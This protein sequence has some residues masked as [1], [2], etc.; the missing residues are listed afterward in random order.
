MYQRLDE[1]VVELRTRLG[2]LPSP[3]EAEGI[4][5]DIWHQEAHNST[6]L[7][8]NT[9]VLQEVERLLEEG[10]AVGA[11]PLRDYMEVRG[12]GDAA[13]W[14]YGQALHPGQ[15]ADSELVSMQEVR[16]I[17]HLAM[18]PVWTVAPHE[19]AGD[20]EG[21]GSFRQHDI[22]PFPEGMRPPSWT[23][24]D[25]GMHD[26]VKEANDLAADGAIPWAERVALVHNRFERVHPFIDGNGRTGRLLLNLLL[27]RLGYPPAII[28]KR[29]RDKYLNALRKADAGD[30][31]P[32]GE[33]IA[34]SVTANLYRFVMPAVAGPVK[35]L[36]LPALARHDM[37][38]N[39]L[40]TA[41]NRGRL[42]AVKGDDGAWRSSKKWVDEYRKARHKRL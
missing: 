25:M 34:R 9:L 1:A 19:H 7:E 30:P 36:P 28:Y 38:E 41:A 33:L 18:T 23:E 14:V 21:P 10:R 32:L 27:G 2:G 26:W 24:V 8:G 40:R 42:R 6:A 16:H 39:A 15:W 17:H 3:M 11:K 13:R 12:Y 37:T 31:G 4:W 22:A 35:L 29:E 5:S 20:G